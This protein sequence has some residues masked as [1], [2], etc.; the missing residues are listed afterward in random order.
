MTKVDPEIRIPDPIELDRIEE[1][2]LRSVA[3]LPPAQAPAGAEYAGFDQVGIPDRPPQTARE[4]EVLRLVAE[5]HSNTRIAERLYISPKTASVH[6]SRIIAKLEV[7]NRV[8]AAAVAHRLG[9]L[10]E[11]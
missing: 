1:E 6:V 4:R 8:E 9:L 11:P 7:G 5:G 3:G 2:R 10:D